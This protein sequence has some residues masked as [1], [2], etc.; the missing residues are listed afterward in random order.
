M[1][2]VLTFIWTSIVIVKGGTINLSSTNSLTVIF[3]I[4]FSDM[5]C[6][7]FLLTDVWL[8][9]ISDSLSFSWNST[10]GKIYKALFENGLEA[11]MAGHIM[12]PKVEKEI[13]GKL[14]DEDMMSATLSHEIITR[15]LC[16][17][18]GFNG[19]VITDD[20][21]MVGMTCH[22]KRSEMLPRAINAGCV[23]ENSWFESSYGVSSKEK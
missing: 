23:D 10:Y 20:S 5:S 22:M 11:V 7:N 1:L 12:L 13:N 18:M 9:Q 3:C 4:F 16:E 17:R 2:Y 15:L 6:S 8:M 19:L 21:H 14:R